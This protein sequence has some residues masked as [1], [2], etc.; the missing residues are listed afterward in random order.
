MTQSSPPENVFTIQREVQRKLGRNLLRLQQ[1]EKL[2]KFL[3][4]EQ[5]IAGNADDLDNAQSLRHESVANKTLG[6]VVGELVGNFI[7]PAKSTTDSIDNDEDECNLT[8][9]F[10]QTSFRI[11]FSDEDFKRTQQKLADLVALRNELVHHF[12]DK[13]DLM[14][15]PGCLAADTYRDECFK[16][17][18][19]Y[20]I[21]LQQWAK[22]SDDLRTKL[23]SYMKTPEFKDFIIHGI[24]PGNAGVL[25]AS[26]TIVNLLRDAEVALAKEGWTLLSNAIAYIGMREAEQTP[27]K[28]GC[29]SW[30][31]VLHES[32]Q[33][34]L[35]KVQVAP[36]LPTETWYRSRPV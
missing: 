14:T 9:P 6:Q 31:H 30:R 33:F 35:R 29:S 27:K 19:A 3:V 2:A 4:A 20:W 17:I 8:L 21:E 18:D 28:Y 25:S 16:Q 12:L 1:Y 32:K 5:T 11:E 7:A 10:V 24:M 34:E 13:H 26:C 22:H 15:E 36:D 23:A